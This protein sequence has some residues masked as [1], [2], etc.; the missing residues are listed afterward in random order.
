MK[1][2]ILKHKYFDFMA[3]EWQNWVEICKFYVSTITRNWS[4]TFV[5]VWKFL[6][7]IKILQLS[8]VKWYFLRTWV[9][10]TKFLYTWMT[11]MKL[12]I[13]FSLLSFKHILVLYTPN[14]SE[15][16]YN[17]C[18]AL[19]D[20]WSSTQVKQIMKRSYLHKWQE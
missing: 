17:P 2:S 9:D 20:T 6:Q 1:K 15:I 14:V 19:A 4:T 3:Q 12:L 7:K 18:F 13:Y 5:Y 16:F 8:F 11:E 10:K